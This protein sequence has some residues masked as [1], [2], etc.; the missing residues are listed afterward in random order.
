MFDAN[1]RHSGGAVNYY[2][3]ADLFVDMVQ[4]LTA[5]GITEIGLYFPTAAAQVPKFE[6]I[7]KEIIPQLK[8]A[9]AAS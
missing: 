9:H 6:A 7:A 4:R 8:A 2:E 3:S 5:L 1:A